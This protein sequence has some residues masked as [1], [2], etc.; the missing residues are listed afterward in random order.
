[1]GSFSAKLCVWNPASPDNVEEIEAM[2][3]AG[4]AFSWIH[5]D[6][7]ERLGALPLRRMG[8]RAIDGCSEEARSHDRLGVVGQFA[9]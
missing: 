7:L 4:A 1:M 5:R 2:V 9:F 6:H 8:F 3:D